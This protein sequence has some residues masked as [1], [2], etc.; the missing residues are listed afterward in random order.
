MNGE[1]KPHI[2][3]AIDKTPEIILC[4]YCKQ[5]IN[6]ETDQYVVIQKGTD[7]YPESLAHVACEQKGPALAL[8]EWIRKFRWPGRS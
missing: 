6:K 4:K 7:R 2:K 5:S 3:G 8:D 1:G